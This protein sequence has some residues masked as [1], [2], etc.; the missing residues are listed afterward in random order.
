[1]DVF[2]NFGQVCFKNTSTANEIVEF[3]SWKQA[4]PVKFSPRP[5]EYIEQSAGSVKARCFWFNQLT[6]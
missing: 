4:S 6:P 5:G 2:D 1:M 3:S